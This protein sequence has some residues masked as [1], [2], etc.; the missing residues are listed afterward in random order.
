MIALATNILV[1]VIAG[2]LTALIVMM[3]LKTYK[4]SPVASASAAC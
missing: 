1:R 4:Q 3:I 2:V